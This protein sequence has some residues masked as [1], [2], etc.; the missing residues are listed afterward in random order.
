VITT[1]GGDPAAPVSMGST[2]EEH[3]RRRMGV[4]APMVAVLAVDDIVLAVE[5][6]G[7]RGADEDR[8]TA[9]S[10]NGKAASLYWNVNANFR[11]TVAERGKLLFAGHPG[12]EA[13]APHTEDLDFDDYRHRI[14]KGLTVLARVAGRGI[15]ADDIDAIFAADQGYI[16]PE[17]ATG[18]RATSTRVTSR[19]AIVARDRDSRG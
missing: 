9:L 12:D 8:L 15:T 16:L 7:Y 13:G 2:T 6:N 3:P 4:P 17:R 19:R 18:T 14:A 1:F 11:L 10:R 5:D